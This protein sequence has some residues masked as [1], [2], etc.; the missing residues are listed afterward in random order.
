MFCQK[1]GTKAIEGA[2]FC[3]KCGAKLVKDEDIQSGPKP[4]TEPVL[5]PAE[6]P[7]LSKE[8]VSQ[9]IETPPLLKQMPEQTLLPKDADQRAEGPADLHNDNNASGNDTDTYG[10]IGMCSAIKSVKR[11]KSLSVN[12]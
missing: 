2:G 1:C 6:T 4:M 9:P 8:P 5:K 10:N 12:R 7:T 3:Q 11:T